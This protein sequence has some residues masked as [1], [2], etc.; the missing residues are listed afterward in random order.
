MKN[1]ELVYENYHSLNEGKTNDVY[2]SLLD[3]IITSEE[4]NKLYPPNLS[5][6]E[7][8]YRESF[9]YLLLWD[10]LFYGIRVYDENKIWKDYIGEEIKNVIIATQWQDKRK[11]P[12]DHYIE[13]F[14]VYARFKK[15][16]CSLHQ[17]FKYIM[18]FAVI[19]ILYSL[20]YNLLFS[21]S[22]IIIHQIRVLFFIVIAIVY[23]I[24]LK[25][26]GDC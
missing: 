11:N 24:F 14:N 1:I 7:I 22:N 23:F 26:K 15:Q 3:E 12:E 4:M 2:Y 8:I 19:N 9:Q 16:W 13:S 5:N 6:E 21:D 18:I 17:I 10:R 20:L 25:Y